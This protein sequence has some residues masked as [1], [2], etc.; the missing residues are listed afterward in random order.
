MTSEA[1]NNETYQC[2]NCDGVFIK[3]WSDEEAQA[4]YEENFPMTSQTDEPA[5][6][7]DDC[8]KAM[9]AWQPPRDWEMENSI[10]TPSHQP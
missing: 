8:Y 4:E 9:I 3:D 7:C 6:V 10:R 5:V 1:V 2:A